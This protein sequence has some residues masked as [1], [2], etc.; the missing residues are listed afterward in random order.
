MRKGMRREA[1][2]EKDPC[3]AQTPEG[4]GV[5]PLHWVLS[6]GTG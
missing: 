2:D 4:A 6:S 1:G 5:A 3:F